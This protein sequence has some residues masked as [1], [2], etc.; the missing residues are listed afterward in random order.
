MFVGPRFL[1]R[2][3]RNLV[4]CVRNSYTLVISETPHH[5]PTSGNARSVAEE[6]LQLVARRRFARL[7]LRGRNKQPAGELKI[8]AEIPDVL[9][10]HGLRAPI[11][12]LLR[13]VKVVAHAVEADP[14]V[15]LALRT[16][17]AAS[18]LSRQRPF[19]SAFPAM[20]RHAGQCSE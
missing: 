1:F 19:P 14:Q 5:R 11:A 10:K 13:R 15:R 20:P 3:G 4:R 17:F 12:A 9:F 7:L 2:H 6:L 16:A 8:L 18:R